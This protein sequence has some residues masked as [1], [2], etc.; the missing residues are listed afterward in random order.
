[1]GQGA[2]MYYLIS[3]DISDDRFRTKAS[4]LLQGYGR[5]VQKSVFECP[6]LTERQLL[7]IQG[8]LDRLI[9]HETDSVR[10]YRQCKGCLAQ[11]ELVGSGEQP[12]KA[13][14]GYY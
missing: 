12:E 4:K 8:E 5:R 10:F 3:Y 11:F 6:N 2:L 9:D 1:M 14:S 7:R 13:A